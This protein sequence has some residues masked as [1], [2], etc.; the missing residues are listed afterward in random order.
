MKTPQAARSPLEDDWTVSLELTSPGDVAAVESGPAPVILTVVCPL[1]GASCALEPELFPA[2][3]TAAGCSACGQEMTLIKDADGRARME[4]S[5]EVLEGAFRKAPPAAP[6]GRPP[7]GRPGPRP[8]N[9]RATAKRR[10]AAAAAAIR[11]VVCP[12][13]LGR[14]RA[15]T[16]GLPKQGA[17]ATCPTCAER[18]LVKPGDLSFL[19][20]ERKACPKAGRSVQAVSVGRLDRLEEVVLGPLDPGKRKWAVGMALIVLMMFGVEALVL[21]ASWSSAKGLS[22]PSARAAAVIG[23]Y[24]P[25][26]LENDLRSLQKRL[27]P[28]RRLDF[29]VACQGAESRVYKFAAAR[30]APETCQRIT[31]LE[32][33]SAEP[34]TGFAMVGVC[35]DDAER[36]A[37]LEVRWN[38]REAEIFLTGQPRLDRLRVTLR[39]PTGTAAFSKTDEGGKQ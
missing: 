8:S 13:C 38:G 30:L 27:L 18:F 28:L 22:E 14:Y 1:C 36:P 3:P 26:D 11:L 10:S 6:Q 34:S 19:P 33:R 23:K 32:L 24:G 31:G 7:G 21:R 39:F 5:P 15:S 25:R 4:A 16:K 29:A 9:G 12:K 35:L 37:S 2:G 20:G 17:W